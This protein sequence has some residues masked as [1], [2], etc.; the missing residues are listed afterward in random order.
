MFFPWD[1]ARKVFTSIYISKAGIKKAINSVNI[2]LISFLCD[3][4]DLRESF[5]YK[6]EGVL[7]YIWG[8]IHP[9]LAFHL[10]FLILRGNRAFFGTIR[11]QKLI[12][13][14]FQNM[15][16]NSQNIVRESSICI[17]VRNKRGIIRN[18]HIISN[19]CWCQIWAHT[20]ISA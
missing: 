19:L 14:I 13:S 7:E 4:G 2:F 18:D 16:R 6:L 17:R 11:P 5:I 8:H 10:I 9:E 15:D 20:F 1:S 12:F 3:V